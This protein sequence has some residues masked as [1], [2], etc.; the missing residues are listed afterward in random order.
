MTVV[1]LFGLT[2]CMIPY[3]HNT[4]CEGTDVE[5]ASL[6][7]LHTG[8]TTRAQVVAKLGAPNIDFVDQRVIAYT[9]AGQSGGVLYVAPNGGASIPIPSRRALMIRFGADDTVADFSVIGRPIER[10]PY[11]VH[12][13]SYD[14]AYDD[15]RRTLEQ[16]LAARRQAGAATK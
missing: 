3:P 2:G 7:W 1:T 10:V 9:W 12:A 8:E 11:S 13:K 14:A 15:W 4:K 6:Q 16:W 5:A